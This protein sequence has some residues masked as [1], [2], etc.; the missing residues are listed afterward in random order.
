MVVVN[1]PYTLA[2]EMR[3]LLPALAAALADGPDAAWGIEVLAG[4][5]A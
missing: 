4:E 2:A 5:A 3:A 1:P